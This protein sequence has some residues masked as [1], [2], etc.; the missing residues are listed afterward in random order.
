MALTQNDYRSILGSLRNAGPNRSGELRLGSY[1]NNIVT[2][3][4]QDTTY[5]PEY[6][7][8]ENKNYE[9]TTWWSPGVENTINKG[10]LC[11][12]CFLK[13]NTTYVLQ[14]IDG[15]NS[16]D[17]TIKIYVND[18]KKEEWSFDNY[19]FFRT[20]KYAE[21]DEVKACLEINGLSFGYKILHFGYPS[22]GSVI[23]LRSYISD[24][25]AKV[26][27]FE[28]DFSWIVNKSGEVVGSNNS[29][30]QVTTNFD[31]DEVW[32]TDDDLIKVLSKNPPLVTVNEYDNTITV[33]PVINEEDKDL[34]QYNL[35]YHPGRDIGSDEEPWDPFSR[36][37]L[38]AVRNYLEPSVRHWNGGTSTVQYSIYRTYQN[39][40]GENDSRVFFHVVHRTPS[41]DEYGNFQVTLNLNGFV[42]TNILDSS[43]EKN[44]YGA[45]WD[46]ASLGLSGHNFEYDH[47]INNGVPE[48]IRSK[49]TS[50]SFAWGSDAPK[51]I[52]IY[53]P[54]SIP[55]II[56]RRMATACE[57]SGELIVNFQD[58]LKDNIIITQYPIE[59][60]DGSRYHLYYPHE[61]VVVELSK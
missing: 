10:V 19:L 5:N 32:Y 24:I 37:R 31:I 30:L 8:V 34:F 43:S 59:T 16:K 1:I 42:C 60:S 33:T 57:S 27:L 56:Q 2:P 38:I 52:K 17:N 14:V 11:T 35:N 50:F 44:I 7:R 46:L 4:E 29:V 36:I 22:D 12:N 58:S 20:G 45:E 15:I 55:V 28:S 53:S 49:Y 40:G 6:P 48:D 39:T 54:Y 41:D 47:N 9:T 26:F 3:L 18:E 61:C 23:N 21:A 51:D 25:P 13:P